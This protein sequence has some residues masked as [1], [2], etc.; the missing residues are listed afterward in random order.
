MGAIHTSRHTCLQDRSGERFEKG[1]RVAG[2]A[3]VV[4]SRSRSHEKE[5][6]HLS[7]PGAGAGLTREDMPNG[8]HFRLLADKVSVKLCAP[9]AGRVRGRHES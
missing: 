3:E 6:L 1:C 5:C 2:S 8:N 9:I 7:S 4:C